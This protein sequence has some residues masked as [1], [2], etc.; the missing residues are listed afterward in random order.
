M[1]ALQG[2]LGAPQPQC[3]RRAARPAAATAAARPGRGARVLRAA[4]RSAEP[5]FDDLVLDDAYYRELGINPEELAE[6]QGMS[7][8]YAADPEGFDFNFDGASAL[9]DDLPEEMREAILNKD[10]YGPPVRACVPKR[11]PAGGC[12]RRGGH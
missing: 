12:A 1:A 6:Q 5:D 4:N 10:V 3:R 7:S 9:S 8:A 2:R 11:L